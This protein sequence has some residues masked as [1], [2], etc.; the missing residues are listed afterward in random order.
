[1][2][3]LSISY[4]ISFIFIF[5]ILFPLY[6]IPLPLEIFHSFL[7]PFYS[8]L[9]HLVL[10]PVLFPILLLTPL[11]YFLLVIAFLHAVLFLLL[12]NLQIYPH[13]TSNLYNPCIL[14]RI[15]HI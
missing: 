10:T 6:S 5:I 9:T 11:S 1:M 14:L 7:I 15:L 8:F 12:H 13:I 4:F 3:S 2:F